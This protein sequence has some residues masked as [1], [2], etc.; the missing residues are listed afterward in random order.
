MGM[1]IGSSLIAAAV[2]VACDGGSGAT[3]AATQPPDGGMRDGG[4]TVDDGGGPAGPFIPLVV[5]VGGERFERKL[6]AMNLELRTVEI[7]EEGA[8][9]GL[10]GDSNPIV[11]VAPNGR[12]VAY[13]SNG[14][15][16]VAPTDQSGGA[17][18]VSDVDPRRIAWAPDGSRI[19]IHSQDVDSQ[20]GPLVSVLP[21]GTG[22]VTLAENV[23]Y[24]EWSGDSQ[25]VVYVTAS[26]DSGMMS[27]AFIVAPDGTGQVDVVAALAGHGV[28]DIYLNILRESERPAAWSPDGSRLAIVGRTPTPFSSWHQNIYLLDA[29]GSNATMLAGADAPEDARFEGSSVSWSPDGSRV[30]FYVEP[31]SG[32]AALH[33]MLPDGTGE[34]ITDAAGYRLASWSPDG[35]HIA[36]TAGGLLRVAPA[37]TLVTTQLADLDSTFFRPGDGELA[38]SPDSAS[39]AYHSDQDGVMELFVAAADGSNPTKVSMPLD[40][41]A[42]VGP[43]FWADDSSRLFYH[44][45]ALTL[46]V[47]RPSDVAHAFGLEGETIDEVMD[48]IF[49]GARVLATNCEAGEPL[50]I[51]DGSVSY[52][53]SPVINCHYTYYRCTTSMGEPDGFSTLLCYDAGLGRW[54][55]QAD[56]PP[57]DVTRF[58]GL[59]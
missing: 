1:R 43:F 32:A 48:Q 30:L 17:L 9:V 14:S 34:V 51:P 46:E 42:A 26:Y 27:Q 40:A 35:T 18:M 19:L 41:D 29:D 15:T 12:H 21:D 22:A 54:I 5:A 44:V 24:F 45:G 6:F 47:T 39:I 52:D 56:G 4:G 20:P 49:T 58:F 7:S 57:A 53:S 8:S 31:F 13:A 2:L 37:D 55:G 59:F 33:S 10:D 50:H 3:D 38:W 28:T 25:H 16:Y 36:L 23:G 11:E